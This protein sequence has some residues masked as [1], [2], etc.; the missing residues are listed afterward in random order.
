MSKRDFESQLV[1]LDVR[2]AELLRMDDELRAAG[3]FVPS[4]KAKAPLFADERSF[5]PSFHHSIAAN[6]HTPVYL[7]DWVSKHENDPAVAVSINLVTSVD[8]VLI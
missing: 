6:Q 1:K 8:W 7:Q 3:V 4:A 5:D 2:E